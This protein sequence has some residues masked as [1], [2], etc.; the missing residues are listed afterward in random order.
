M[1]DTNIIAKPNPNMASKI[2][3][4][5]KT[6]AKNQVLVLTDL[7]KN[8]AF[9]YVVALVIFFVFYISAKITKMRYMSY[10]NEK[11]VKNNIFYEFMGNML[12]IIII[13]I[14]II[15]SFIYVG[16]NLSTILI[17]LSSVGIALALAVQSTIAQMVSGLFILIFDL[18]NVNDI[19]EINGIKG[20]VKNFSIAKTTIADLSEVDVLIPN[21]NFLKDTF[22]NYTK[23]KTI[24]HSFQ[25]AISA[26][27]TID[28]NILIS[29]L[30]NKIMNTSKYCIDKNGIIVAINEIG[31]SG[32]TLTIKVPIKSIDMFYADIELKQIARNVMTDDNILLLDNSYVSSK[33]GTSNV[34]Y[35]F[36]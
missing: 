29:N 9:D 23:Q 30:K 16:F 12:Y 15:I 1:S 21:S 7:I 5:I 24:K 17:C 8:K 25:I 31:N 11:E 13:V 20:Y 28:Y 26:N 32:T 2:N 3:T 36:S 22:I 6:N 34:K 27:N 14:G 33:I 18:Y 10:K 19:V 4:N 35:D